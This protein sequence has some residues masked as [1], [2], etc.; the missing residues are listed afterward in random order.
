MS[1]D[2]YL[3]RSTVGS[4]ELDNLIVLPKEYLKNFVISIILNLTKHKSE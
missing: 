3:H 1:L 4:L 2:F